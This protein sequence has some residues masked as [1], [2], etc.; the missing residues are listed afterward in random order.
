MG[1]DEDRQFEHREREE[2]LT[3]LVRDALRMRGT[4]I[5]L[6]W[7]AIVSL[8]LAAFT[9]LVGLLGV[10]TGMWWQLDGKIER[11]DTK[12]D[13]KIERLGNKIDDLSTKVGEIKGEL[14]GVAH[15]PPRP[16]AE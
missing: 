8:M 11:F 5:P 1:F 3:D 6:D 12:I 7:K 15:P 4:V 10:L 2:R 16:G 13:G 14:K 9:V